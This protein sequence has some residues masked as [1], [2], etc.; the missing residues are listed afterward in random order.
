LPPL[1]VII[2]P[3]TAE[4]TRQVCHMP[5][6]FISELLQI[7]TN[8]WNHLGIADWPR[9]SGSSCESWLIKAWELGAAAMASTPGLSKDG[10]RG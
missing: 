9:I 4:L 1:V 3:F 10:K 8:Y 6:L 5:F 2:I 7:R